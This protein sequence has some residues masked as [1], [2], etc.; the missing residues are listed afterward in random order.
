MLLLPRPLKHVLQAGGNLRFHKS[1]VQIPPLRSRMREKCCLAT[2]QIVYCISYDCQGPKLIINIFWVVNCQ[3]HFPQS[4]ASLSCKMVVCQ[5]NALRC[6]RLLATAG[7]AER[8]ACIKKV[9]VQSHKQQVH[10][11]TGTDLPKFLKLP[12][13]VIHGFFRIGRDQESFSSILRSG[14]QPQLNTFKGCVL[15]CLPCGFLQY[16]FPWTPIKI[17][18]CQLVRSNK[19]LR[20]TNIYY[21]PKAKS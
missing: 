2:K 1:R 9:G 12:P 13:L 17:L 7:E 20:L 4:Q 5:E 15:I 21:D 18:L 14:H 11:E 19:P 6:D 8:I 10:R 3:I 16:S